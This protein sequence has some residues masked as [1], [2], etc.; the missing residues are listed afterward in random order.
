MDLP[1]LSNFLIDLK[2]KGLLFSLSPSTDDNPYSSSVDFD[3]ILDNIAVA[4][5]DLSSSSSSY[6]NA[7]GSIIL[8]FII[9]DGTK[10]TT[11]AEV[12]AI[13]ITTI[14]ILTRAFFAP[15]LFILYTLS[16]SHIISSTT[17]YGF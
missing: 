5:V 17:R 8:L 12:D 11:T 2:P 16:F 14:E 6:A 4:V 1:L 3:T 15:S 13:I 9:D 7:R 10:N